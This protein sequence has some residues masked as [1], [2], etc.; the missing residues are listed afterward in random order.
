[1]K[2]VEIIEEIFQDSNRYWIDDK[3]KVIDISRKFLHSEYAKKVFK[4]VEDPIEE[5]INNGWIRVTTEGGMV[6]INYNKNKV[7]RLAIKSLYEEVEQ[8]Y[9]IFMIALDDKSSYKELD[10]DSFLK[11]FKRF[12]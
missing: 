3:G 9:N 1:M 10:V 11:R 6:W 2:L 4:D 12:R 8:S 5:T 7:S